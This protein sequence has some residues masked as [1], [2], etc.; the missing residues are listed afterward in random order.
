[1]DGNSCKRAPAGLAVLDQALLDA[2]QNVVPNTYY[3]G[4]PMM[5]RTP[6]GLSLTPVGL[7][8]PLS[9]AGDM[10]TEGVL[11]VSQTVY[12]LINIII[13]VGVLSVPYALKMSGYFALILVVI[14]IY[15]TATTGKWLGASVDMAAWSEEAEHV[16]PSGRGYGFLALVSVGPKFGVLINF[17]T[18]LEIWF[19]LVTFVVLNGVNAGVVWPDLNPQIAQRIL[20]IIS[21]LFA[22][23]PPGMFS[24]L[25]LISSSAMVVAAILMVIATISMH[26]WARPLHTEG[27][28]ALLNIENIPR[29]VGI[30]VFC[31]AGHP[32]F[33]GVQASMKAPSKW[34]RAVY[35]S[36]GVA[37]AYYFA[38]GYLGFMVFGPHTQQ[39]MI[40]NIAEIPGGTF[41]RY[42][43]ASCFIVKVG[44]T[45]PLLL[46]AIIVSLW[47]PA[48]EGPTW[49][50]GRIILA[51]VLA[52]VTTE[53][54][55]KLGDKVAVIASL[56][57]SM[58]VMI[59]S[60]IFPAVLHIILSIK[61]HRRPRGKRTWLQYTMV[62]TFG[63][64]MAYYGTKFA[65]MD[66]MA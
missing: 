24:Y 9:Q 46:N 60:V 16:P 37:F 45:I 59:T 58:L 18:V 36:F 6:V 33:P 54:A 52:I 27:E 4:S 61:Y 42:V 38:F 19:A 21:L 5:R 41:C 10:V 20:M 23:V 25:S 40:D 26:H 13:G 57:G 49:P 65:I 3:L 62:L 48:V 17:I 34:K 44:L 22:F 47:A 66:L 43:S 11:S 31:F 63:V 15:I 12:N 28:A 14:V 30:I 56:A 1:M 39:S 29:S 55:L 8:L 51:T 7:S 53:A 35:I 64:V 50:M 2:R 32:C